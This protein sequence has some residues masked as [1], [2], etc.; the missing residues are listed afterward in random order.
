M[1][2]L[3]DRHGRHGQVT[4][5][6]RASHGRVTGRARL[7]VVVVVVVVVIVCLL[8]CVLCRCQCR[9]GPAPARRPEAP[10]RP[11]P[12]V[13]AAVCWGLLPR[14]PP[15]RPRRQ[16]AVLAPGAL[17]LA[18][19]CSLGATAATVCPPG[20]APSIL[21]AGVPQSPAVLHCDASGVVSCVSSDTLP[22]SDDTVHAAILASLHGDC[23]L[24]VSWGGRR[25][26]LVDS[27]ALS[28]A[29]FVV[30]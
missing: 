9:A 1:R 24:A 3:R 2:K 30:S 20:G 22:S 27:G 5:G 19:S 6:S 8:A 14:R 25:I 13:A 7:F 15:G 26:V 12:R 11:C 17:D 21:L 29:F 16:R 28:G 23:R 10:A 4:G 18:A